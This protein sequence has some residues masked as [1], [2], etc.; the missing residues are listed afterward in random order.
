MAK[1]LLQRVA[2]IDPSAVYNEEQIAALWAAERARKRFK[3][4]EDRNLK[5]LEE[6]PYSTLKRIIKS[7]AYRRVNNLPE[8]KGRP[9]SLKYAV[10]KAETLGKLQAAERLLTRRIGL[11]G[12]TKLPNADTLA[13]TS[14]KG[15]LL[16]TAVVKNH[17]TFAE[18]LGFTA[19]RDGQGHGGRLLKEIQQTQ[20]TI[21]LSSVREAEAFYERHG[22]RRGTGKDQLRGTAHFRNTIKMIWTA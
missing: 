11:Q 17:T 4:T 8:V 9:S 22:F 2:E 5:K 20:N 3:K 16:A 21:A 18:I 13:L 12:L 15:T 19:A 1:T 14:R 7:N 10:Q 6:I